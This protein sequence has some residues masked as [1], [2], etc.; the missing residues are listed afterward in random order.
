MMAL[1]RIGDKSSSKSMVT[2]TATD[3]F[4]T[5]GDELMVIT[6]LISKPIAVYMPTMKYIMVVLPLVCKR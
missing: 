5:L 1:R 2:S 3:I 4:G 6:L